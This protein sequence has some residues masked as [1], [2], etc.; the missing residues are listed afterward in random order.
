M[1][2]PSGSNVEVEEEER[3]VAGVEQRAFEGCWGLVI[4]VGV[5]AQEGL[6]SGSGWRAGAWSTLWQRRRAWGWA[7]S[8]C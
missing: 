5:S 4:R 6:P 3:G 2:G 1:F 8:C 7:D